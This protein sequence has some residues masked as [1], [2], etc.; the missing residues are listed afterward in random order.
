VLWRS[1]RAGVPLSAAFADGS[2]VGLSY[3][4]RR[5]L[6]AWPSFDLV[7]EMK[8]GAVRAQ[9]ELADQVT[10]VLGGHVESIATAEAGRAAALW[11][12][13]SYP[14]WYQVAVW[15]GG[16]QAM[17]TPQAR[18]WGDPCWSITGELAV[19][20]FDGI[21]RGIVAI[22]PADGKTRWWSRPAAASYRLLALAPG[23]EDAVAV[24]CDH[25]GSAWLVRAVPG[26]TDHRLQLLRPADQSEVRVVGWDHDGIALEGLRPVLL[27]PAADGAVCVYV[28]RGLAAR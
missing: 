18:I 22:D 8:P 28:L 13:E 23:G 26:G 4:Q 24:R 21:R 19:T 2:H 15:S 25:D 20:C 27:G 7:E 5:E 1:L 17:T 3:P 9:P 11:T 6:R 16:L 12:G 14:P 10:D